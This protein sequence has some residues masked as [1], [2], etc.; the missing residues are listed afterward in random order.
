MKRGQKNRWSSLLPPT[1]L[2]LLIISHILLH[3]LC[4]FLLSSLT[5]NQVSNTLNKNDQRKHTHIPTMQP[6]NQP[7]IMTNIA[8]T[9]HLDIILSFRLRASRY[10]KS[11]LFFPIPSLSFTLL[12]TVACSLALSLF[13]SVLSSFLLS[14]S[15]LLNEYAWT[16]T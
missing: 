9:K 13:V 16:Y 2:N 12:Y 14:L 15:W 7:T 8:Q 1:S 3:S 11:K 4:I 10:D 6:A 5:L